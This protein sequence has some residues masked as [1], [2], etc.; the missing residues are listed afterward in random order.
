[1][2]SDDLSMREMVG[3]SNKVF[4]YLAC[5]LP[6]IVSS[7]PGWIEA[8][9]SSGFGRACQPD[10]PDSIAEAVTWLLD[11]PVE[12]ARMAERGRQRILSE[13]HYERDFQFVHRLMET[14]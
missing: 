6:L 7:L 13:W 1:M 8:Y 4:D 2:Q 12:R 10:D 3:A 5:G 11:H 9:V 14:A